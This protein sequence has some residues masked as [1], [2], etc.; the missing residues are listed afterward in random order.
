MPAFPLSLCQE[1]PETGR[2]A[3][4]S[5]RERRA[6]VSVSEVCDAISGRLP[7]RSEGKLLAAPAP[8]VREAARRGAAARRSCAARRSP[9]Q[10][11]RS[12]RLRAT[13]DL[14]RDRVRV[15]TFP[16]RALSQ[17]P[18]RVS[19]DRSLFAQPCCVKS[20]QAGVAGSRAR[21]GAWRPWARAR[22]AS[23]RRCPPAPRPASRR[24]RALS[25]PASSDRR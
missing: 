25:L 7:L 2:V 13:A 16:R 9:A 22:A 21:A 17:T 3:A 23:A 18:T 12:L 20:R 1:S 15:P 14:A 24:G 4:A 8:G 10:G 11:Y 19:D 6:R 5:V